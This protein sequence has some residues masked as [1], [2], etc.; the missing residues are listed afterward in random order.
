MHAELVAF[1][2]E[3]GL[4]PW[5]LVALGGI[6]DLEDIGASLGGCS[7]LYAPLPDGPA[8]AQTW[9]LPALYAPFL[10]V[11]RLQPPDGPPAV[12]LTLTGSPALCGMNAYGVGVCVNDLTASDSRVGVIWPAILRRMLLCTS[13]VEA[14]EVLRDAPRCGGRAWLVA[15]A[16]ASF[17]FEAT[18]TRITQ[19][20]ADPKAAFWHTNHYVDPDLRRYQLPLPV[21]STS[22]ERYQA[23]SRWLVRTPTDQG[24]LWFGLGRLDPARIRPP[25]DPDDPWT[26]RTVGGVLFDLRNHRVLAHAGPMDRSSPTVIDVHP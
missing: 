1:A 3:A 9:D 15:D 17:A 18:A 10:R 13:A 2:A 4:E 19:V 23:L 8:L 24:A 25:V 11:V 21:A 6:D 22:P 7:A 16:K 20:H 12:L 14:T 5:Q 26:V